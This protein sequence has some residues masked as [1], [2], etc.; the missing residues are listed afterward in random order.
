[1]WFAAHPLTLAKGVHIVD[2]DR[3]LGHDLPDVLAPTERDGASHLDEGGEG[4]SI[5]VLH[6][7]QIDDLLRLHFVGHVAFR[8]GAPLQETSSR[9]FLRPPS[10][11]KIGVELVRHGV[12][13]AVSLG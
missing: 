13:M 9:V 11:W 6:F 5:P 10:P 2:A 7:R 8:V 4:A 1:M 12:W 3:R